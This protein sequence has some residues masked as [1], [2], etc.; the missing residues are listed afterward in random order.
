MRVVLG[1]KVPGPPGIRPTSVGPCTGAWRSVPQRARPSAGRRR[2]GSAHGIASGWPQANMP[3]RWW[4]PWPG[5][6][7]PSW[8]LLPGRCPW[9]LRQP[10]GCWLQQPLARLP[11]SIGR[12][13]A[14]VW[15][16]PRWR[17]E[18]GSAARP[19]SEAG[20]RRRRG[21]WEPT[22]GYQRD[23]PSSFLAPALP[24]DKGEKTRMPSVEACPAPR[25]SR[26]Y[27]LLADGSEAVMSPLASPWR[28]G[29]AASLLLC[30][31]SDPLKIPRACCLPT[32]LFNPGLC[33][34]VAPH[35]SLI[36]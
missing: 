27:A 18:P 4:S 19:A 3:S 14:P 16:H 1:S 6:A 24:R 32:G 17:E 22:H 21:R 28:C 2:S 34:G 36:R 23:Q 15:C 35:E 12:G 26:A 11:T 30:R 29:H 13:A 20:T 9:H 25:P 7:V 5:N 33:G 31:L 10:D 8:G